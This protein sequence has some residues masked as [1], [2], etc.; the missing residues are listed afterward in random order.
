[1]TL[2]GQSR[3]RWRSNFKNTQN[4]QKSHQKASGDVNIQILHFTLTQ[5]LKVM[6][7]K[8]VI[9]AYKW[10]YKVIWEYIMKNGIDTNFLTS[11]PWK[12]HQGQ[13]HGQLSKMLRMAWKVIR[14]LTSKL[15]Q[16][17]L[18]LKAVLV[19]CSFPPPWIKLHDFSICYM[20]PNLIVQGW[21]KLVSEVQEHFP[22]IMCQS[23]QYMPSL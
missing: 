21:N 18:F 3:S 8:R 17:N 11:W 7:K 12:V 23:Y 16:H 5:L 14:K 13:V 10:D 6:P 22:I 20:S 2:K 19:I 1:M 15:L 4:D 9:M